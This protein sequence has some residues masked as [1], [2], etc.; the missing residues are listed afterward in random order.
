[1]APIKEI[2]SERPNRPGMALKTQHNLEE[3]RK[4]FEVLKKITSHADTAVV[5]RALALRAE[6]KR[7]RA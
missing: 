5:G 2:L 3:I 6:K 1:M 7:R 4:V